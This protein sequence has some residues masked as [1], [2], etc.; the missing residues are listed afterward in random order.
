MIKNIFLPFVAAL[1]MSF[2]TSVTV[3]AEETTTAAK[4]T[5]TTVATE[6]TE[7]AA[8]ES[9]APTEESKDEEDSVEDKLTEEIIEN[10][11]EGETHDY[12][13]DDYYDTKG[14]AS[15]IKEESIIYD[16]EEMQF[17]AVTTKDGNVFYVLI[18]YSAESGEDSVYFL[19]KV[20]SYDLYS[21]LYEPDEDDSTP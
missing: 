21:L 9:E 16:Y 20:D 2:T 5:E 10:A 15:L 6:T 11:A 3:S 4:A 18:N 17:I 19:N 1:V 8:F 7:K 12:Y 14:N 13:G